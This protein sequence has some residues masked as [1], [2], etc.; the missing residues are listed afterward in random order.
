[1]SDSNNPTEALDGIAS[2]LHWLG[3][4]DAG[5]SMGAIEALGVMNKEG[6]SE[7]ATAIRDGLESI[8]DAI[9]SR[10]A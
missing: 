3:T 8:A 4:G 1:M 2:A 5:T 6:A 7:I 9:R 10:E